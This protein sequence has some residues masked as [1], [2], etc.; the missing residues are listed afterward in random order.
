MSELSATATV[1]S[2]SRIADLIDDDDTGL[3]SAFRRVELAP[4]EV[5]FRQGT[6]HDG[7]YVVD[8]GE[9]QVCR[10]LPGQRELELARLGPGELMGEIS[11]LGGGNHSATVR[12]LG[13]C[14]LLFL[15]WTEF[16]AYT[17]VGDPSALGLRRRIVAIACARLRDAYRGLATSPRSSQ[18]RR[19]GSRGCETQEAP[20]PATVPPL[21]YLSQLALFVGM[22]PEFVSLLLSRS[23]A[24]RVPR[25][26]V[27]QPEGAEVDVCHV[28]LN[29]AVEDVVR[30][31]TS[32]RRVGFAGPGHACGAVGLL[33]GEPAPATSVARDRTLLLVIDRDEL[34][35]LL[36]EPGPSSRAL[37]AAI[38][39]DVT[40]SLSTTER[41]L[42]QLAAEAG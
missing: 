34:E 36:A 30:Q 6:A 15:R 40:L 19:A 13:P 4:G 1:L 27:V 11:L 17:I 39:A 10:Q 7:L 14:T 16:D 38:E 24:L 12:A 31:D 35:S 26:Y 37:R 3:A 9:V 18:V 28:V 41:A 22:E 21:Q 5:L 2:R 32:L 42:A 29:G 25:G 8:A 20:L 33:D 23:R